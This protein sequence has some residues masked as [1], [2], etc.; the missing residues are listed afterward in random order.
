MDFP[1][2]NTHLPKILCE[3][4]KATQ[5]QVQASDLYFKLGG[6]EELGKILDF[7]PKQ[8]VG[9]KREA[10]HRVNALGQPALCLGFSIVS[11]KGKAGDLRLV[12]FVPW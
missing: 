4:F 3:I 8:H 9:H 12:I 1:W 7:C 5:A 6:K 2:A 10:S 11:Y